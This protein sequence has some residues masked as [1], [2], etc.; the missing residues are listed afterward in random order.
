MTRDTVSK[1][2]TAFKHTAARV[3]RALRDAGGAWPRGARLHL[4]CMGRA[5]SR[6]EGFAVYTGRTLR[7]NRAALRLNAPD[8]VVLLI[9]EIG[10]HHVQAIRQDA[11]DRDIPQT[12]RV[13]AA[14]E[15]CAVLCEEKWAKLFGVGDAVRQWRRYRRARARLD[16][17]VRRGAVTTA[18]QA[19]RV[20]YDVPARLVRAA[21]EL[22]RV[23]QRPG[24]VQGYLNGDPR[25]SPDC[26]CLRA[27]VASQQK[28]RRVSGRPKK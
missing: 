27:S 19:R 9:H 22:R 8:W 10:G 15:R 24:E 11:H 14:E 20:F 28:R 21:A 7:V 2:W 25:Q 5:E 17:A 4:R 16:N 13:M 18:A 23:R 12:S 1:R 26:P 6:S 3:V